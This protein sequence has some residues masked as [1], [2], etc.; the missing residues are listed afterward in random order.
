M[1][2]KSQNHKYIELNDEFKRFMACSNN[3]IRREFIKEKSLWKPEQDLT[4]K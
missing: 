2:H 4:L 1:L 3:L